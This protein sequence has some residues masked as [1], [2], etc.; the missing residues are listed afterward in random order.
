MLE[1]YRVAVNV[2]KVGMD[3]KGGAKVPQG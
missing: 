1:D 2:E 3:K